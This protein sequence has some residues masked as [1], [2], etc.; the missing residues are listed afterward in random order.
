MARVRL[1]QRVDG[2]RASSVPVLYSI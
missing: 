2:A 1:G